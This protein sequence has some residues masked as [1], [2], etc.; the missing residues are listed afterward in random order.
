MRK[1]LI[2]LLFFPI[3]YY[4]CTS[5]EVPE[6]IS[7]AN[8]IIEKDELKQHILSYQL[9]LNYDSDEEWELKT[10]QYRQLHDWVSHFKQDTLINQLHR[11]TI[12]KT[13]IIH[14]QGGMTKS[15]SPSIARKRLVHI[16]EII[17]DMLGTNIDYNMEIIKVLTNLKYKEQND[18]EITIN[19][20]MY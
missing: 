17:S 4:A 8:K 13:F 19:R 10:K 1:N 2:L 9:F 18:I 14:I 5:K 11:D 3:A 6:N 20:F 12:D 15:L 7:S 16:R